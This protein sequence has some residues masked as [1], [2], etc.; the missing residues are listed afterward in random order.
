MAREKTK[1]LLEKNNKMPKIGIISSHTESEHKGEMRV[2]QNFKTLITLI[3]TEDH[4]QF[5]TYTL[6]GSLNNMLS[7]LIF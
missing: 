7:V 5:V 4:Y 1:V 2:A 3:C 6:F